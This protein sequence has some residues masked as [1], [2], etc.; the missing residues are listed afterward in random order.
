M[1]ERRRLGGRIVPLG[2]VVM[3]FTP[4]FAAADRS[5]LDEALAGYRLEPLLLE[6]FDAPIRVETEDAL[7]AGGDLTRRRPSP[8]TIWVAEGKPDL[9]VDNGRLVIR[10]A[11]E[12]AVLWSTL[13]LP[14]RFLLE[15]DFQPVRQNGL[16][17]VFFSMSSAKNGGDIFQPGLAR[18]NADFARYHSGDFDG[19][20]VSYF[21]FSY[22]PGHS[23]RATT[24]LRKH[25][26]SLGWGQRLIAT[27][28]N[29]LAFAQA[30]SPHR[31]RL[32]KLGE[33]IILEID[34]RVNIDI[35]DDN[36]QFGGAL[37]PGQFGFRQMRHTDQASYGYVRAYGLAPR[38]DAR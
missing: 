36:A 5:E 32:A 28:P 6:E 26:N 7:F 19:Y 11:G 9:A 12:H 30:N 20:H 37:G 24:N 29:V 35:D 38:A 13:V 23:A 2:I 16:A 4:L 22:K 34:G 31:L 15:W 21:A 33:R 17:I 25:R 1:L 8:E 14:D 3:A 10:N 27:G 18:R